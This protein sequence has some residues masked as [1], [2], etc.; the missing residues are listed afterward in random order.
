MDEFLTK[1]K[2]NLLIS[3]NDINTLKKYE[4]DVNEFMS[5]NELIFKIEDIIN[6]DDLSSEEL[7]ELD[8]ISQTLQE[9]NYY[10]NTNK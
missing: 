4:I 3:E 1:T 7:D 9:R 8:Y 10:L 5:I 2:N 6:N